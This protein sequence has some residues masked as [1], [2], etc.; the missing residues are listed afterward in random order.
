MNEPENEGPLYTLG[1]LEQLRAHCKENWGRS[2]DLYFRVDELLRQLEN[3]NLHDINSHMPYR[4][5][6][7]D[8]HAN[9]IRWIVAACGTV[10][11]GHAAFDAAIASWPDEHFTLRNGMQLLREYPEGPR[12]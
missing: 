3:P 5:E 8:R 10:H 4:V 6:L 7:W 1:L 2:S 12:K 9:H 11:I